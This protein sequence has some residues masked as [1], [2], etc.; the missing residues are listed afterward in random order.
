LGGAGTVAIYTKALKPLHV[1][2]K[3]TV[4]IKMWTNY[5]PI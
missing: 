1:I 4:R 5:L 3:I 2:T